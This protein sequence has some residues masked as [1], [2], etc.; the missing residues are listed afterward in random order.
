MLCVPTGREGV[1]LEHG[2]MNVGFVQTR[3]NRYM[4]NTFLTDSCRRDIIGTEEGET[5][6]SGREQKGWTNLLCVHEQP[7]C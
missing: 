2:G 6:A 7:P 1:L 5:K 3:D 4:P